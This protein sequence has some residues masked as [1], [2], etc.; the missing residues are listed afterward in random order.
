MGNTKGFSKCEKLFEQFIRDKRYLANLSEETIRSYNDVWNRWR[1]FIADMPNK[2][3]L[4]T[5]VIR[6]REAGL[7]VTTCNISIRSFNSFLTWLYNNGHLKSH[8]RIKPL[9]EDQKQMKM[10]SDEQIRVL[11][12]WKPDVKSRNEVRIFVLTRFLLDTGC[13]I[14]EALTLKVKSI[15]FDNLL[16]TVFGKGRKSRT[17]PISMEMRKTFHIYLEKYRTSM[18]KSEYVFCTSSG[19]VWSYQNA[20]RE[21]TRICEKLDVPIKDVDGFF[22]MFRRKYAT[23]FV[24]SGGNI[25]YLQHILGHKTLQMTRTY[26]H[27][28]DEDL[29]EAHKK[30]SILSRLFGKK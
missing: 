8:L 13:R 11:L 20:R 5:F 1:R 4:S 26:V 30:T 14:S 7:S 3:N 10:L 12:A 21:L 16:V 6:M 22:H 18:F 25:F 9:K 29:A 2:D 17:I 28:D 23:S 15:D 27:P 24:K 19:A